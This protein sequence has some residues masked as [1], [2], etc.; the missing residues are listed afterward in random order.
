MHAKHRKRAEGVADVASFL[1][2][3]DNPPVVQEVCPRKRERSGEEASGLPRPPCNR[4]RTGPPGPGRPPLAS[5]GG[6][7]DARTWTIGRRRC[8]HRRRAP[9]RQADI[10]AQQGNGGPGLEP[11]RRTGLRRR[12]TAFARRGPQRS[13]P[14]PPQTTAPSQSH[15]AGPLGDEGSSAGFARRRRW[16]TWSPV[17][18]L[19]AREG[20]RKRPPGPHRTGVRPACRRTRVVAEALPRRRAWGTD[21]ARPAP[22]GAPLARAFGSS[23]SADASRSAGPTDASRPD[24]TDCILRSRIGGSVQPTQ[25]FVVRPHAFLLEQGQRLVTPTLATCSCNI[26]RSGARSAPRRRPAPP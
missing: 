2:K 21:G 23:D 13:T 8:L 22:S 20:T 3:R 16:P 10:Y 1:E 7:R 9:G 18:R 14:E 26:P 6:T 4:R 11:G 5:K 25:K 24:S 12:P 15:D 17:E 19:A